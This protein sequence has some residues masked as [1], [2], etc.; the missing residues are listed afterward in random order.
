MLQNLGIA[1]GE[2]NKVNTG[3]KLNQSA[4]GIDASKYTLADSDELDL[5]INGERIH[6]LTKD[7]TI[8]DILSKINSTP[9]AGVKATYVDATGQFMLVASETGAGRNIELD[10]ELANELLA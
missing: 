5:V 7:S 8:D 1:Y 2:S 9:G 4:L 6:G 3:G 10:S